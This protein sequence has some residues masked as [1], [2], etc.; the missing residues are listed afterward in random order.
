[1]KKFT[2]Y[3]I[4][5]FNDDLNSSKA[6]R[7]TNFF[8]VLLI[9]ISTLEVIFSSEPSF[10]K[11]S[12]YLHAVFVITSC[13]F[14]VEIFFRI[15]VLYKTNPDFR[16]LKAF[17]LY[18]FNFYNIVD[19]ISVLPFLIGFFGIN[20]SP[21][22][23]SLRVFRI[24]K[25]IR[26]LPSISLLVG[27]FK[28]KKNLLIISMQ[29]ILILALLLSIALYFA[30]H[31]VKD[32]NFTSISQALLWS[33]A[34][35]IGDIGGYGDFVPLT[36]TGKIL[37]TFNGILGIAIFAI[38]AG[39]IASGFVEEI[40]N[41]EQE[42]MAADNLKLLKDVFSKDHLA[43]INRYKAKYG[44]ENIR[45]RSLTLNDL[46]YKLNLTEQDIS[47]IAKMNAGLRVRTF[48]QILPND[49]KSET[50]NAEYFIDNS[51]Y[52]TFINKES[53]ITILTTTSNSQPFMGHFTHSLA[54]KLNANYMSVEK[55]S[56]V[57]FNPQKSIDFSSNEAFFNETNN[58]ALIAFKKDLIKLKNHNKLVI[59]IGPKSSNGTTF[60]LLNGGIKGDNKL[61]TEKSTYIPVEEL[62]DFANNFENNIKTH[63]WNLGIHVDYGLENNNHISLYI[64][65]ILGV[66]VFQINISA[67][68]L[69]NDSEEYYKSIYILSESIKT[70]N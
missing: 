51:S 36:L 33:L 38:P 59:I 55:Y 34:K 58:E 18:F 70:L 23:K 60:E 16:G 63:N 12:N 32:S 61:A 62:S 46:K 45:R 24:F 8:I 66:N 41:K 22:W 48:N 3:L 29:S 56:S 27:A 9:I 1:M 26:Y 4:E 5:T 14:I 68:L 2:T 15:F 54:E 28:N 40:E 65:K 11:Y 35:F 39:I 50:V 64:N 20:F 19:I 44:L 21:F 13:V 10:E 37:A 42:K 7:M 31:H 47:I 6:S 52:G 69:K 49:V 30:E 53:S 67:N 25:I 57:D 43:Q 17:K